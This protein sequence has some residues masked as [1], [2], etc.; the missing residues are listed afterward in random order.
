MGSRTHSPGPAE[1]LVYAGSCNQWSGAGPLA[2]NLD[3]PKIHFRQKP[4][5]STRVAA[6]MMLRRRCP[7]PRSQLV[8]KRPDPP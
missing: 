2:R 3:P 7:H 4:L 5:G 1:G 6:S 8:D